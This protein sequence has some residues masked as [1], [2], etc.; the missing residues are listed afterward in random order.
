MKRHIF[1]AEVV[2]L[3]QHRNFGMTMSGCSTQVSCSVVRAM[4]WDYQ[5]FFTQPPYLK[6]RGRGLR[7][8]THRI[9]ARS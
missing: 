7:C 3:R 2:P 5:G 9:G 4:V 1:V 6:L 8:F